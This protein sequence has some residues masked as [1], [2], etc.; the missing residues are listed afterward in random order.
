M[1]QLQEVRLRYSAK[2]RSGNEKATKHTPI[3]PT[4]PP[5]PVRAPEEPKPAPVLVFWPILYATADDASNVCA[6]V[7]RRPEMTIA[8]LCL[9]HNGDY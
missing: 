7:K 9:L 2:A 5:P 3:S 4:R 1:E 6:R 8:K